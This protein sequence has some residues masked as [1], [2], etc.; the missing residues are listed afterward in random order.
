MCSVCG[1]NSFSLLLEIQVSDTELCLM[2]GMIYLQYVVTERCVNGNWTIVHQGMFHRPVIM[3][4]LIFEFVKS[5][6]FLDGLSV[7]L[8]HFKRD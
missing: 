7:C 8:S 1:N 6:E 3:N 2:S 4:A 5:R